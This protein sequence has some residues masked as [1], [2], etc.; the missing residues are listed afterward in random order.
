MSRERKH[1]SVAIVGGGIA[2][3]WLLRILSDLGINAWLFEAEGLGAGQTLASQGMIHGGLKYQ[4]HAGRDGLG[5]S[6]AHMPDFWLSLI[7]I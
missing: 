3:V 4:L 5:E 2:G 6:L 7:H 1:V